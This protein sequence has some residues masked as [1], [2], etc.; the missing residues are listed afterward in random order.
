[1]RT[2]LRVYTTNMVEH[3]DSGIAFITASIEHLDTTIRF[4]DLNFL[5]PSSDITQIT[6]IE[7]LPV[8]CFGIKL[9]ASTNTMGTTIPL[10]L[11]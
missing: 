4:W 11:P 6:S 1:M 3:E 2:A 9:R 10:S 8:S 5:H 7:S